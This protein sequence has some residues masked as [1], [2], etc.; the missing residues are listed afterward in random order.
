MSRQPNNPV[1]RRRAIV[2]TVLA[3]LGLTAGA[4]AFWSGQGSGTASGSIGTLAAPSIST[5]TP[6]AGTVELS[7]TAVTPPG[8]GAVS[9]YV[10]RDGGA[11]GGSC[12][13]FSSPSGQTSCTDSEV[14][15]GAHEYTVT[16]VWRSWTGRSAGKSVEVASAAATHL[17]LE[18]AT[19]TPTAGAGDQLT[20]TAKDASN[21]VVTS[22]SGTKSLT[23]G[24]ASAIGSL[25]PTV[26]DSSGAPTNFGS[27]TAI[28]FSNGVASVSGSGNG[29]MTLY[30]AGTAEIT[31][32]DGTIGNGGGLSVAVS[33]A[34][35]ASFTVPT[36]ATQTAGSA[37]GETLTAL[38]AYGNTATGYNGAK[39]VGFSG[40]ASSPNSTAPAYPGSVSFSSGVGTA[41]ITLS[42]AESTT[43]TAKDGAIT[44][45]SGSF[46]VSA[47]AASSFSLPTPPAQTAGGA[48]EE[49]LT[50]LDAYGNT[51]TGYSGTKAVSFSGPSSSPNSTV[52]KYP[53]SVSF[54][55]G[56]GK[57]S[58]TLYKAE[59]T[60]LTAKDGSVSGSS[61]SFTVNPA[62][63]SGFSLPT[64]AAQTA[65]GAFEATLTALDA[66]GNTATAYTGSKAIAFSGPSSSPNA[67]APK[68]PASVSFSSGVGKASIILYKAEAT[69]LTAKEGAISGSSA[70]FTVNPATAASLSLSAASTTPTAG[71]ADS[72]T[73]AAIDAY[74]NAATGYTGA[75]SLT[76]GGASTI[77]ANKPTVN[78]SS[79]TATAFGT[80]T[81]INFT[82]GSASASGANNGVMKLY[83]VETAKVTVSDGTINNGSGLS[84]TVAPAAI[85]SIAVSTPATQ[86]AGTA[87]SLALTAKDTYG[88][89][90]SGSQALTF[91]GPA[92][93]PNSTAPSYPAS[94]SFT[95]GSGTASVTL[96]DAQATTITVKQG[97]VS[98]TSGSFTVNPA[99]ASSLSLTAASTT[100][101]AGV[102]DSLTITALDA[103]GNTATGYTGAKNLTLGGASTIGTSKPT[104]SSSSGA[105]TAF[106]TATSIT[107]ASGTAKVSGANNGVMTLYKAETANVT[108]TDGSISNGAG[109]S[110]T[111][112]AAA[113]AAM[114]FVNC[115]TTANPSNTTCTGQPISV[116]NNSN[117]TFNMQ[118]QDAFGNPS[119]PTSAL[120]ITFTNSDAGFTISSGE[121][122]TIGTGATTSGQVT[123]HHTNSNTETT[124]TAKASGFASATLTAK[125]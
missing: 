11:P 49:M 9:Y 46:T 48:F 2:L 58:I 7:W 33:P 125:R 115:A 97:A 44:G 60:A 102:A 66:Y 76:F 106:G 71:E 111:V 28:T 30:K 67:T 87:F 118:T 31:V 109:L 15:A 75:K 40:P 52:P 77:G 82:G 114:A 32:T 45:T 29:V 27:A 59:S 43:L 47:A 65:G 61:G 105:A 72:L 68:Y 86:T 34:A 16:A 25:H 56:V 103:Y 73:I 12:P 64:P 6:G 116:G 55:S 18:A 81:S 96:S 20:I 98:G 84:V 50:A 8:S 1:R 17:V 26:N 4:F 39:T 37:F 89:G 107:F 13:S 100:P 35:A 80:T 41:S 85:A 92:S 93:S 108:V 63:A 113:A 57:A 121:P 21:K 91:S 74:G 110:V 69:T 112:K 53:T 79:G 88:N 78:N 14:I 51:A 22:Y 36:A 24:G 5:A 123:L 117:M 19:T 99:T 101:T 95:N 83:S 124:L 90:V 23:F 94:V 54:S 3:V 122:A 70:S 10:S 119:S 62:I 42:K 38:D 120:S 104:V